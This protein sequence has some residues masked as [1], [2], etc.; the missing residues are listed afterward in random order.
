MANQSE[1]SGAGNR[2]GWPPCD[3][4]SA[5]EQ[6]EIAEA[7]ATCNEYPPGVVQS[8][9][10][11]AWRDYDR[12]QQRAKARQD[13]ARRRAGRLRAGGRTG[14]SVVTTGELS[15]MAGGGFP[16]DPDFVR[17]GQAVPR[18]ITE[19]EKI[20]F[21]QNSELMEFILLR[22]GYGAPGGEEKRFWSPCCQR[23]HTRAGQAPACKVYS[24]PETIAGCD[25]A[26]KQRYTTPI[27]RAK[28]FCTRCKSGGDI[29]ALAGLIAEGEGEHPPGGR[30]FLHSFARLRAW[31]R[32]FKATGGN[33]YRP[34][35]ARER[36]RWMSAQTRMALVWPLNSRA[37]FGCVADMGNKKGAP[38]NA[39]EL[40][41]RVMRKMNSTGRA[42][43]TI[44]YRAVNDFWKKYGD[45]ARLI[46][47]MA[48]RGEAPHIIDIE[49]GRLVGRWIEDNAFKG[50]RHAKTKVVLEWFYKCINPRTPSA[51]DLVKRLGVCLPT[52]MRVLDTMRG[53]RII[54]K[55]KDAGAR[56]EGGWRISICNDVG[57][58][59]LREVS[60]C[61]K[62]AQGPP[63]WLRQMVYKMCGIEPQGKL[64]GC[65]RN[66]SEWSSEVARVISSPYHAAA[67]GDVVQE[68]AA[69]MRLA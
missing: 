45:E 59:L 4:L 17:D 11:A 44:I 12:E 69:A 62:R 2:S 31:E 67:A 32:D 52:A 48:T 56:G 40:C 26:T 64:F 9:R 1:L 6:A 28:F 65:D 43:Q 13:G 53:L 21:L 55:P 23:V 39:S 35:N 5:A 42:N 3:H 34:V 33:L 68:T 37:V 41:R 16:D 22:N 60:F 25:W 18:R 54:W 19:S 57:L 14:T 50:R 15:A 63:L 24:K 27:M 51:A 46:Y 47:G 7:R 49:R 10:L 29:V 8:F 58:A 61:R 30:R 66:W 20:R 36:I 38:A